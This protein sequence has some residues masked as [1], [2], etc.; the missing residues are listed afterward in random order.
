MKLDVPFKKFSLD[1]VYF[2]DDVSK[3]GAQNYA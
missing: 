3:T 2:S 1:G